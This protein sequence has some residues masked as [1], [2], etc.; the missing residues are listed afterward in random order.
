MLLWLATYP[1][2]N[3]KMKAPILFTNIISEE[4]TALMLIAKI[5]NK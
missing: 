1:K 3:Q 5:L 4:N 2:N